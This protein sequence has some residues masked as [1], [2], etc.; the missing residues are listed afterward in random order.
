[1]R[2]IPPIV[3][4]VVT[5]RR[6]VP[7]RLLEEFG[8]NDRYSSTQCRRRAF[9]EM[10]AEGNYGFDDP[11]GTWTSWLSLRQCRL[12]SRTVAL[13]TDDGMMTTAANPHRRLAWHQWLLVPVVL[14]VVLVVAIPFGVLALFSIPY[15]FVFPDH[16]R[17]IWDC[18][19]TAHQRELLAKWRGLYS[20]MG[21]L[22]RIRRAG[23]RLRRRANR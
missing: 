8:G 5:C 21:F 11:M 18:E 7:R 6:S 2:L 9:I 23:T 13:F 17:H 14:P 4:V 19:G 10:Q 3:P 20:R 1:M 12:R 22:A 16:H 15:Y